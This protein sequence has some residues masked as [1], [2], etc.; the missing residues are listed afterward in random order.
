MANPVWTLEEVNLYCGVS[1]DDSTA[2]NHLTLAEFKIPMLDNQYTDHRPGGAPIAIEVSTILAR[3]ECTFVL[4]G[5]TQQVLL[6]AESWADAQNWFTG[7]GV[8][9][10]QVTGYVA[11][12]AVS[13]QGQLGRVDPQNWNRGG[14]MHTNYSIRGIRHYEFQIAGN[15]IYYWDFAE[16]TFIV[17]SINR[18]EQINQ[19]LRVPPAEIIPQI[20][21]TGT[22]VPGI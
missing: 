5:L 15:P 17:G 12:A 3:L 8:I 2:S 20:T 14:I 18:W 10:D 16:N 22:F 7:F 21:Q 19:F 11:Q 9:R 4:L 1:P 13:I 6:L